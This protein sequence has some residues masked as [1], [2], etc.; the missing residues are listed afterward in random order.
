M[1]HNIRGDELTTPGRHFSASMFGPSQGCWGDP[2]EES[3]ELSGDEGMLEPIGHN[4]AVM[5]YTGRKR[6]KHNKQRQQ[7]NALIWWRN[8]GFYTF[9]WT[10]DKHFVMG[11]GIK[12]PRFPFL[13]ASLYPS[14]NPFPPYPSSWHLFGESHYE[15]GFKVSSMQYHKKIEVM[16]QWAPK[17]TYPQVMRTLTWPLIANIQILFEWHVWG[18]DDQC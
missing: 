12:L 3:D 17:H 8:L 18:E 2:P 4:L 7:S 9:S 1:Q 16:S 5:S 6:K 11:L 10:W 15:T 14:S 13:E